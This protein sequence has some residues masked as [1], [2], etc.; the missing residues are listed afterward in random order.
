M[1]NGNIPVAPIILTLFLIVGCLLFLGI[2]G[3]V[4][5]LMTRAV[6]RRSYD[7]NRGN[8]MRSLASQMSFS[9]TPQADLSTF[10]FFS[11]FELFEGTPLKFENLMDGSLNGYSV[12]VFDLAY[13]NIGGSG[14]G[15]TTSRQTIYGISSNQLKLPEFYHRPEGLME[16]ALDALSKVD[17]DFAERTGFSTKILLYGKDEVAIRQVFT[18]RIF[19]FF[20]QNPY[21]CVFAK[22]S[23]VLLPIQ[24][25]HSRQYGQA[26][27]HVSSYALQPVP[28]QVNP[29][30]RIIFSPDGIACYK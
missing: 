13:R 24:D 15:T 25:D 11:Q 27:C 10:P 22:G 9:F 8:E 1:E 21:L 17:I 3:L 20:E 19:D 2:V 12:N 23:S 16:R 18:D 26:E 30:W 4:I 6:K 5:F 7:T 14:S 28:P 29:I